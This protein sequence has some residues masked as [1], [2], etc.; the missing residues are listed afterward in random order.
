MRKAKAWTLTLE[1]SEGPEDQTRDYRR[2]DV[3]AEDGGR[4]GGWTESLT[5][6]YCFN[7]DTVCELVLLFSPL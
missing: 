3:W 4:A 2:Q 6:H 7:L 5:I 1:G